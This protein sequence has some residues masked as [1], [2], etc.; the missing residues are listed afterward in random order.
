MRIAIIPLKLTSESKL[1]LLRIKF[2]HTFFYLLQF[3]FCS[4]NVYEWKKQSFFHG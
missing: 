3:I 1:K 2:L 4:H